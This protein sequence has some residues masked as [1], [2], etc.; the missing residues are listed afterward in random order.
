MQYILVTFIHW[1][2]IYLLDWF[3]CPLNNP[4]W[5]WYWGLLLWFMKWIKRFNCQ[6]SST[7]S[8]YTILGK[9]LYKKLQESV[10]TVVDD[11]QILAASF[12]KEGCSRWCSKSRFSCLKYTWQCSNKIAIQQANI[13]TK[14]SF[15]SI[16][17]IEIYQVDSVINHLNTET[18][19]K[20][21]RLV[22]FESMRRPYARFSIKFKLTLVLF[23]SVASAK[24]KSTGTLWEHC[25]GFQHLPAGRKFKKKT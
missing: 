21:W 11:C 1:I 23:G 17:G 9:Y 4:V 16:H 8:Y 3:I 24:T 14:H 5:Y 2:A 12:I 19:S 22:K 20:L 25:D 15:C 6:N 7:E 18:K 10:L 13:K